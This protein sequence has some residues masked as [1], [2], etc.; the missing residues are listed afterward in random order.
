MIFSFIF[1]FFISC[2]H[3]IKALIYITAH[4][5]LVSNLGTALP[6]NIS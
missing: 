5:R 6:L 2:Y 1:I 3:Y 4:R